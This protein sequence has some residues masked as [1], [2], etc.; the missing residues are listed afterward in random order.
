MPFPVA[1]CCGQKFMAQ[2]HLSGKEVPCP[3]CGNPLLIQPPTEA[4]PVASKPAAPKPAAA[5]PDASVPPIAVRCGC[6][7]AY[8][9]P[10]AMR[11]KALKC[12][13]C[14][15]DVA[16]PLTA[17]PAAHAPAAASPAADLFGVGAV[18]LG[19]DLF[20][21]DP[22]AG[23][24]LGSD[25]LGGDLFGGPL[26]T[27]AASGPLAMP[28]A[29][30]P[31]PA[32][33]NYGA[34]QATDDGG[35]NNKLLIILGACVG[36]VLIGLFVGIWM[37]NRNKTPAVA[38]NNSPT[39]APSPNPTTPPVTSPAANTPAAAPSTGNAAA[40]AAG[41][42][43][44]KSAVGAPMGPMPGVASPSGGGTAGAPPAP[45]G[46]P[47]SAAPGTTAPGTGIGG[48]TP[49]GPMPMGNP[50]TNSPG[51]ASGGT[52]PGGAG[53]SGASGQDTGKDPPASRPIGKLLGEGLVKAHPT[54]KLIGVHKVGEGDNLQAH[55][56][57]MQQILPFIGHQDIYDKFD[58]SKPWGDKQNLQNCARIIPEFLNPADD[59]LRWK[60]YPFENFA[61]THFVGM[62]GIEDTRNEVAARYPRSDPRAGVFG[63]DAI[64]TPAEIT[65]GTSNTIMV[66]GSGELASPWVMGGGATI[67]G[68]REPNF[69]AIT[70]FGSKGTAGVTVVMADGS[71][72]VISSKIN[73]TVFRTLCT[74]H[75]AEKEKIDLESSAPLSLDK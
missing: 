30:A 71:V 58:V 66:L 11:G 39:P 46:T 61:L 27:P 14:G 21:A 38:A 54:G 67:R 15:Q 31:Q 52:S 12:P 74:I 36:V 34:P 51:T 59:R 75:G 1:C 10:A 72:R 69:D 47:G 63:Y 4:A 29:G 16:I 22:F 35:G 64:A 2:D 70:G 23:A 13:A 20:G 50:G 45:A 17:P 42:T 57:W 5:K 25:P 24:P 49:V 7:K 32:Q 37:I 48:T 6:G 56:S 3:A 44:T 68:S 43:D 55:Y 18:P 73:P 33:V 8:K 40:P 26:G 62:S 41:G 9:A 28:M 53:N 19:G 65:D 60:G